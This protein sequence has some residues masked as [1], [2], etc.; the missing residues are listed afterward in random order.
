MREI[1]IGK[2]RSV[3][4]KKHGGNSPLVQLYFY[5]SER[6]EQ[7]LVYFEEAGKNP[8]KLDFN[9]FT[10]QY[11]KPLKLDFNEPTKRYLKIP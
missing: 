2:Y 11:L 8:L 9:E 4:E 5:H 10:K 3:Y 6:Y 7:Y 1:R